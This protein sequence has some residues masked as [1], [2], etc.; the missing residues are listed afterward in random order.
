MRSSG[1]RRAIIPQ[2]AQQG[3]LET[4]KAW[5][6][7]TAR[8]I[9]VHGAHGFVVLSD[10]RDMAQLGR[11]RCQFRQGPEEVGVFAQAVGGVACRS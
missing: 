6:E 10:W 7:I 2:L 11:N 1:L 4:G 3:P 5:G 9:L 8:A